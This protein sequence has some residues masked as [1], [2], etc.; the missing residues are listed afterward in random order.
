MEF[1]HYRN[2]NGMTQE[3]VAEALGIPKK[4]YQNYE[5]GV[6]EADS[7]V[8]CALADLYGITLDELVGRSAETPTSSSSVSELEM[9]YSAMSCEAQQTLLIVA[10]AL[11]QTYP[12]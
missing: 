10:K 12:Q 11:A 2:V 9:L 1:K 4:T 8:L 6:R 5:Y 7:D 3:E